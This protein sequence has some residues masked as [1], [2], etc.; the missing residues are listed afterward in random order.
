[1]NAEVEERIRGEIIRRA[2]EASSMR[3][4]QREEALMTR[5]VLD[6]LEEITELPRTELERIAREVRNSTGQAGDGFF[7]LRQQI[8]WA[9]GIVLCLAGIPVLGVWLF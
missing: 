7:S 5:D 3:E 8:M 1:M 6:V 9:G 2:L 4:Q